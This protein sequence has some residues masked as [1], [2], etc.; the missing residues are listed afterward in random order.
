MDQGHRADWRIGVGLVLVAIALASYAS[1]FFIDWHEVLGHAKERQATIQTWINEH[2]LLASLT[3][4]L[5]YVLFT[6]LSLPG[7]VVLTLVG[8]AVFGLWW[9]VLLVSFASTAGATGAFLASRY[10]LRERV[11]QKYGERL[12]AINRE[13]DREGSVYLLVLRLNPV[14][15]YFLINL[16]FGLT[17]LPVLRFWVVSQ[18]GMLPATIIYANAGARLGEIESPGDVLGGPVLL[19]LVLLS[20]FP[21]A[22]KKAANWAQRLRKSN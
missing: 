12:A 9:A 13:L 18:L 16:L 1:T 17:R 4:F 6:S 8:G 5:I 21:L 10:L 15:P 7:A 20:L 2:P 11:Q 22:A 19:S 3:Y 14:V